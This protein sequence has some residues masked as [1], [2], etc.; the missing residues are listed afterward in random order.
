[1]AHQA[2][3][4]ADAGHS[5]R[6]IAGRGE[7]TDPHIPFVHIPLADSRETRV[8]QVKAELDAGRVTPT[9]ATLKDDLVCALRD[10]LQDVDVLIAHNVC[11][12][13]K[14]LALT[15]ALHELSQGTSA[16]KKIILWH[17]DLAWT[18]PRYIHELHSGSPWDLLRTAWPGATQVVISDMRRD[19]LAELMQISPDTI[20]VIPNGLDIL[21]FHKVEKTT[22]PLLTH[23]QLLD[24]DLILLLP[25]RVTPRKNIELALKTL[26]QLRSMFSRPMLVVTGPLGP[27]NENNS[28]Y[29]KAL[30]ALRAELQLEGLAHFLAELHDGFLPDEV[31]S[32]FYHLADA[33]FLPSREEG[34]G[35][36]MLEAAM[37]R[38]PVFCSD[39][40][41]LRALANDNATLFSPDEQPSVIAMLIGARMQASSQHQSAVRVRRAFTWR[42]IYRERIEPLLQ[43]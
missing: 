6:V 22:A 42:G 12:L 24:A 20:S 27:H 3:T 25:V 13:N 7:Q 32:D 38:M 28:H 40:L 14:N 21:R 2:R 17:H 34:F 1:M 30:T 8:V 4:F 15:A 36:P 26:A 41:P 23:M 39:I 19:E 16:F 9:F 29:F 18:T 11:S 5:V 37:S 31:I 43:L 10:A 35:L 33:L